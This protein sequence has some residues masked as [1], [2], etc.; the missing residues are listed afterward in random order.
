MTDTPPNAPWV[1]SPFFARELARRPFLSPAQVRLVTQYNTHG[2]VT[3]ENVVDDDLVGRIRREV[4]GL[5]RPEIEE[6][7]ASYYRVHDAW[8]QSPSVRELALHGEICAALRLLYGREPVPFQTLNFLSGSQQ[9]NHSDAILFNSLPARYMCGVWVALEDVDLESGPLFYYPGSHRLK[10]YYVQDFHDPGKDPDGF[11]GQRYPGF[12]S[13]LMATEGFQRE[14]LRVRKGSALVWS[15]NLVHGGMPRLNKALTRWTQVTHYFFEG[16]IYYAPLY[17]DTVSGELCIR[18]VTDLRTG[19]LVTQT[20]NGREFSKTRVADSRWKLTFSDEVAVP[21]ISVL[22]AAEEPRSAANRLIRRLSRVGGRSSPP[23]I[24]A[25]EPFFH[26]DG[27][28]DGPREILAFGWAFRGGIGPE[29]IALAFDSERIRYVVECA[30]T[31]RP[32]VS[33]AF[34]DS[35][36]EAGFHAR[37]DKSTFEAGVYRVGLILRSPGNAEVFRPLD[38]EVRVSPG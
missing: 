25:G 4:G 5:F 22:P 11:F 15:S 17:S 24:E 37:I 21:R 36:P 26:V 19:G 3:L 31:A 32:D 33:S 2:Y 35:P 18:D 13:E 28:E 27:F 6:G 38:R 1:E 16:C 10:E 29:E 7:Y 34:K 9:A 12:I 8:R 14:Q 30:R 23:R 20:Y